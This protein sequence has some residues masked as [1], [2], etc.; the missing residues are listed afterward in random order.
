[1]RHPKLLASELS[2]DQSECIL[3]I[4]IPKEIVYFLGHFADTPILP[5]VVQ[6][7]WAIYFSA[8]FMGIHK[9]NI[10]D[11][12]HVKFTQVILPDTTLF[13]SLKRDDNKIKFRFFDKTTVYSLGIFK[14]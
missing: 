8:K 6:V 13:L 4:H 10:G 5:G 1:M 7:D 14:I 2:S 12:P 3:E 11:I 9:S